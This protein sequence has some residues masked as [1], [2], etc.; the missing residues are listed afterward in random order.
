MTASAERTGC[1]YVS[2]SDVRVRRSSLTRSSD[3]LI[4]SVPLAVL[5]C[6]L[7]RPHSPHPHISPL[8]PT[9]YL[10]QTPTHSLSFCGSVTRDRRDD[11]KNRIL[12]QKRRR[13]ERKAASFECEC[14]RKRGRERREGRKKAAAMILLMIVGRPCAQPA[15]VR[16]HVASLGPGDPGADGAAARLTRPQ[17]M[18]SHPPPTINRSISAGRRR[19]Q[20]D[21]RGLQP[22]AKVRRERR[23]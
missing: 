12:M 14:E 8:S 10:R 3:L 22:T 13:S 15:D 21:A 17:P 9:D 6:T 4:C 7:L 1:A 18:P 16:L 19:T 11:M 23:P 5:H 2:G 20:A